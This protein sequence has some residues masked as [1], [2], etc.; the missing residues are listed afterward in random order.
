M[1]SQAKT[2][3]KSKYAG[4]PDYIL[5]PKT[6]RWVKKSGAIG[7]TLLSGS[8]SPQPRA[9]PRAQ[10]H[11]QTK[12]QKKPQSAYLYFSKEAIQEYDLKKWSFADIAKDI[13][14]RW[15]ELPE[16]QKKKYFDIA[17]RNQ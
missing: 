14:K 13:S 12:P 17:K 6:G 3:S 5:N 16:S 7:K 2:T 10:P 8:I 11:T 15:M 1:S 4:H 9:Q